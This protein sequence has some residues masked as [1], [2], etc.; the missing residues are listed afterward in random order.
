MNSFQLSQNY[1]SYESVCDYNQKVNKSPRCSLTYVSK[2]EQDTKI[3]F[4]AVVA[5]EMEPVLLFT[6]RLLCFCH[7]WA[8]VFCARQ[9]ARA[10]SMEGG[11]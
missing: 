5:G 2:L 8:P 7:V 9:A 10:N 3:D 11:Y 4:P 6:A 1:F